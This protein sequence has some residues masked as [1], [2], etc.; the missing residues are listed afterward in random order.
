MLRGDLCQRCWGCY[1]QCERD[2]RPGVQV[3]YGAH[4]RVGLS[5]LVCKIMR[6]SVLWEVCHDTSEDEKMADDWIVRGH[7]P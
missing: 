5:K 3:E 7:G 2:E 4:V 1:H 6:V